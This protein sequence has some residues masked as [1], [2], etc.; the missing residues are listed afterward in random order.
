MPV[1][2]PRKGRT[3]RSWQDLCCAGGHLD[4]HWAVRVSGNWRLT[5]AFEGEA[6]KH[7]FQ[8]IPSRR[9]PEGLPG[10]YDCEGGG[11]APR[12]DA[13]ESL[14]DTQRP[15]RHFSGDE[16]TACQGDAVHV[17]RVLAEDAA[18]LQSLEGSEKQAAQN[19]TVS[20][21][22]A[23]GACLSPDSSSSPTYKTSRV[24]V[25]TGSC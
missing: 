2:I 19:Q 12:G 25:T 8:S 9:G 3:E 7:A 11:Q 10:R 21:P 20:T 22:A 13:A 15:R 5:V 23:K 14:P 1:E 4:G 17:S 18:Q 6:A 24:A 16:R